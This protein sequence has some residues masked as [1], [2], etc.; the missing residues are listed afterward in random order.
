[1]LTIDPDRLSLRPGMRVLDAGC[2]HGRHAHALALSP[3]VLSV[4]IDLSL[5][6]LRSARDAWA[7][8]APQAPVAV[9]AADTGRLPFPD[10]AFDRVVCSEVLEHLDDWQGALRELDRV[11]A[12]GGLMALSVPRFWPEALCWR[13]SPHYAR[14]PGGHVRIFRKRQLTGALATQG[15][16]LT[17]TAHAHALHAPYW[18]LQCALWDRREQSRLVAAWRR[19]LEWD[20]TAR[21]R[22]TRALEAALNPVM[23][24]SLV[25]YAEKPA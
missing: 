18:W 11:L 9:A 7:D 25:L 24:K 4:G 8:I 1:V 22:L 23:G 2:G 16:R 10:G 19:F 12:P 3:G 17:G 14:T 21:P 15:L 5:A 20:M 13:L 6:D